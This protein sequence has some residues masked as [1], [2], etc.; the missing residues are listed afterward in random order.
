MGGLTLIEVRRFTS[1]AGSH[2]HQLGYRM[3]AASTRHTSTWA[4]TRYRRI[5]FFHDYDMNR[6]VI[7][8]LQ[9][10]SMGWNGCRPIDR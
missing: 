3:A 2:P 10:L 9:A 6:V 1:P 8:A 7:K 4:G 5:Q